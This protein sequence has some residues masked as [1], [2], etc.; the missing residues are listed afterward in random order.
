MWANRV[1]GTGNDVG[2]GLVVDGSGNVHV[3][4]HFAGTNVDFNPGMGTAPLTS[5]G[6]NDIFIAKYDASGNYVG[7]TG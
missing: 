5:A 4:G 3:T 7:P 1:G 2:Y 6:S